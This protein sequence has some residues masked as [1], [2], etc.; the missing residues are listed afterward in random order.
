M[1]ESTGPQSDD[2]AKIAK[3]TAKAWTEPDFKAKLLADPARY[4]REEG[5]TIPPG[6]TIEMHENTATVQHVVLPQKPESLIDAVSEAER[7]IPM[8]CRYYFF[9]K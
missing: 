3:L 4:M 2:R 9:T 8:A 5:I 6:I 7:V 1:G